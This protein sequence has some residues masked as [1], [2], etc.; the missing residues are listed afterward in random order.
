MA[1]SIRSR[2][3]LRRNLT[4]NYIRPYL[5]SHPTNPL[6]ADFDISYLRPG[7][8]IWLQQADP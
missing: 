3:V 7:R 6:S 2:T 1:P 8:E 5:H 4:L